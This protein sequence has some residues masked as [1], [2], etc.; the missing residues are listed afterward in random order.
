MNKY[1]SIM[2]AKLEKSLRKERVL[3][4]FIKNYKSKNQQA[5]GLATS[6]VFAGTLEGMNFWVRVAEAIG[7]KI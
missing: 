6:F 1:N 7:E 4:R 2:T 5:S 3:T